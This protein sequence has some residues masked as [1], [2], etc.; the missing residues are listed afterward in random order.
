[1]NITVTNQ[2]LL[3]YYIEI[4]IYYSINI[5]EYYYVDSVVTIILYTKN[6]AEIMEQKI[7]QILVVHD[8]MFHVKHSK[9]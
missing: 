9:V 1:M 8:F 6:Q 7:Y 3:S 4:Y 2:N 5:K